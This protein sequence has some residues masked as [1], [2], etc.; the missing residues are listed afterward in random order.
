MGG[1][2]AFE[3]LGGLLEGPCEQ[4]SGRKCRER[5]W[6]WVLGGWGHMY[7]QHGVDM[8]DRVYLEVGFR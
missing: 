5:L 1:R 4:R 7:L 8:G 3:K 6:V 2:K